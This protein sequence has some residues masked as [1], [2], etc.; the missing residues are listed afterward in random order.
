M[1]TVE[2]PFGTEVDI[3]HDIP[4]A[5]TWRERLTS[6]SW[7]MRWL[8]KH[9][10]REANEQ[11]LA[12]IDE[13]FASP[14]RV[15]GLGAD[16]I[17]G[18]EHFKQFHAAICGLL[19]D[20]EISVD[21]SIQD[22]PW[23]SAICTLKASSKET[24]SP[25]TIAGSVFGRIED[26]KVREGHDVESLPN[27]ALSGRSRQVGDPFFLRS[28]SA[29]ADQPIATAKRPRTCPARSTSAVSITS[30]RVICRVMDS[31]NA[32]SSSRAS[33]FQAARRF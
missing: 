27:L 2:P 32:G 26:G 30:L 31:N 9:I 14:G 4:L 8:D 7:F 12:A 3:S 16:A 15:E 22:G 28:D 24:D 21:K 18:P 29:R 1:G 25:V 33:A 17:I 19:S 13:M 20:I 5:E 10:A 23:I 11:H 6:V